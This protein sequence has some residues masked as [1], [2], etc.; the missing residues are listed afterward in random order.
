MYKDFQ[1][2]EIKE[3]AIVGLQTVLSNS[4]TE[5]L[6]KIRTIW[7]Q[8]NKELHK[9]KGRKKDDKNWEK[10]GVTYSSEN[11]YYYI[12]A[13]KTTENITAPAE[14]IQREIKEGKYLL[15]NHTGNINKLKETYYTIYKVLIPENNIE[16]KRSKS[17]L[18]HFERYDNRFHWTKPNS[19]IE[20]Y[21]PI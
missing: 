13:I 4:Q 15:F 9:V 21:I 20:I 6:L 3:F 8:F 19:I 11:T 10:F 12:A 17:G 14:M 2:K 18:L 7:Q 1:I 5:N 16:V